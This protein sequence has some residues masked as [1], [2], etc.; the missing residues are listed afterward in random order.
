MIERQITVAVS[1]DTAFR[2]WTERVS[3][4]WPK[5]HN[6]FGDPK[7]TLHMDAGVGGRFFARNASGEER[8]IG[9][10]LLWGPPD[11]LQM[12]FYMG[13]GPAH[14]TQLD[15]TFIATESGTR[16]E[17]KHIAGTAGDE[18]FNNVAVRFQAAWT[19]VTEAFQTA[20]ETTSIGN[21]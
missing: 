13:T 20:L 10:V 8:D 19:Q 9:R 12:S 16:V 6:P 11:H 2:V 3:L 15:V 17:V 4:W 18:R 1:P 7:A 14:P 5:G 21:W